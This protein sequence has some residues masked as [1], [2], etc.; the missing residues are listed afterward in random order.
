MPPEDQER[1]TGVYARPG[2][3]DEYG[4]QP[5]VDQDQGADGPQQQAAEPQAPTATGSAC[6]SNGNEA[7]TTYN[8]SKRDPAWQGVP[9]G[10]GQFPGING[11]RTPDSA[12]IYHM[13]W[14]HKKEE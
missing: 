4:Q 13:G 5:G 11:Y 12:F 7:W 8:E 1:P 10:S 9:A 14:T 2:Q 6:G 3:Y